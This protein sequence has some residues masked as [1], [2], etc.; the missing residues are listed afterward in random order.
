MNSQNQILTVEREYTDGCGIMGQSVA[1]MVQKAL[2][3]EEVPSAI[4]I[5]LGGYKGMLFRSRKINP[6][7]VHLRPSQVSSWH[8][9]FQF[10]G[11][12]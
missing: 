10:L 9:L 8:R 11:Q 4:Q 7:E 3:L 6:E 5:R 2:K 1:G 12:I